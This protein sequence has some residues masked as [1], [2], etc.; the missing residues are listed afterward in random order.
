[1]KTVLLTNHYTGKP[2]SIVRE[3]L[4]EGFSLLMLERPTEECLLETVGKADYILAGGRLRI[5]RAALEQ[6]TSLRMIQRSGVGLDALD[7]EAIREKGIPL[8]VNQGVNAQSVAEHTLL[9]MLACLR[10][11]TQIDGNTKNGVWKKQEQGIQTFE[12]HGKTVGIIGMGNIATTLVGLLKPFGVKIL[13]H[14]LFRAPADFEAENHMTFT[15]PDTLLAES[16]IVTI[17]CALTE[18]TRNLINA[19]ALAKMKDGAV[20]INTARGGIVDTD[21]LAQALRSGKLSFAGIDAHAREPIPEDDPLKTLDNVI[22]TPHVAGVTGDSFRAMM[23]GAFRNIALF[24][25]GRTDEI[26]PY[27]Y[28]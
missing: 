22:L 12:L 24:D 5:S 18:Q 14:N 28:L 19:D 8:Y 10:R 6:A 20:L 9:L 11:L 17:H 26:A 25:Q 3:C 16:D 27:R 15:D 7:L 4:P 2:Y 13:Y 23:Q 21:A 1:M